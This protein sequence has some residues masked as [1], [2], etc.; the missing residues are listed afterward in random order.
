[1]HLAGATS[2]GQIP[3]NFRPNLTL[4]NQLTGGVSDFG[5]TR[6]LSEC[7]FGCQDDFV[8]WLVSEPSK[9][10]LSASGAL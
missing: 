4:S 9:A 3:N 10:A 1:M 5:R 7:A 6:C 2:N 8:S